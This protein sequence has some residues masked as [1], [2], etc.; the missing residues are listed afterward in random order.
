M[1]ARNI[2]RLAELETIV[3]LTRT[4][5]EKALEIDLTFEGYLLH[6]ALVALLEQ[7]ELEADH[8]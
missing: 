8:K 3:E 7:L 5:K 1:S 2:D 4:A 6:T